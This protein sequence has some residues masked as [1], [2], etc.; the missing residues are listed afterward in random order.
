MYNDKTPHPFLWLIVLFVT[1]FTL[2]G[3]T[4]S[5]SSNTDG[6]SARAATLYQPD[7]GNFLFKK[8]S[9]KRL[10]MASTT[11]IMTA[12]IASERLSKNK[13]YEIMPEA[14]GI[15]GS[16]AYLKSGDMISGEELLYALLLQSANDAAVAIAYHVSGGI[17]EFANLMNDKV[18]QLGLMNT[19]FTNPHGL[20]DENHYTTAEDLAVIS[21]ELLSDPALS[22]IV[23]TYKKTF[24]GEGRQRT[25]VNHNKLLLK[26]DDTIGVKTGFTKKSGRCLVGAAERDGLRFITVTLDAPN[27]WNDHKTLFDYGYKSL[28]CLS[29]AKEGDFH[30]EIPVINGKESY[31]TVKNEQELSLILPK[32]ERE[33]EKCVKM[34]KYVIAPIYE[35]TKLG[36][37]IFTDNGTE[38]GRVSLISEKTVSS[39][40]TKN[41]FEKIKDKLF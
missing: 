26:Y 37:V 38:L 22:E 13:I 7:T 41:I 32:T 27:D 29:L 12:I 15:E 6:I 16:S 14:V 1:L 40:K 8:N 19:H 24:I 39:V 10:P 28:E 35:G 17:E 5:A 9:S 33:I 4:V 20:D 25:Y 21:S 2:L 30:Y 3:Y 11:K 23:S 36:E 31:L 18:S 34:H